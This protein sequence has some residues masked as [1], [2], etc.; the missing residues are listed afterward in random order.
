MI[1]NGVDACAAW[2]DEH[3]SAKMPRKDEQDP[4]FLAV[5]KHMVHGCAVAANGCKATA[6]STCKR[7][8]ES[9][10]LLPHTV[11]DERGFPHYQRIFEVI[12]FNYFI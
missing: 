5:K 2:V 9:T 6:T 3:I 1:D 8:Y 12:F 11:F 10:E 7:G 4:Y